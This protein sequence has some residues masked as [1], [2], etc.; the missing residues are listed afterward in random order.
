MDITARAV[1]VMKM[2]ILEEWV[3]IDERKRGLQRKE[4][5]GIVAKL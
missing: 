5:S 4:F 1:F 2:G 3:F